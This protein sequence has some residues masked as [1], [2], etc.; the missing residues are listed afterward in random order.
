M[1]YAE[2]MIVVPSPELS[3]LNYNDI[4]ATEA[5]ISLYKEITLKSSIA[6]FKISQVGTKT[7][8]SARE[9]VAGGLLFTPASVGGGF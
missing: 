1:T 8:L 2:N 5:F 7:F 4:L 3:N 6:D 9:G